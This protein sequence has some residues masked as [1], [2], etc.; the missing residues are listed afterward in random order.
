MTSGVV[1]FK[2]LN[3]VLELAE[4]YGYK[5][6]RSMKMSKV[7][8]TYQQVLFDIQTNA[9]HDN[10]VYKSWM[11]DHIGWDDITEYGEVI[12]EDDCEYSKIRIYALCNKLFYCKTAYDWDD[13]VIATTY[14]DI[15]GDYV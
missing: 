10:K 12:F 11:Y 2:P 7:W 13:N 1:K 6:K 9:V 5:I 8:D 4:R 3:E 15:K 14:S